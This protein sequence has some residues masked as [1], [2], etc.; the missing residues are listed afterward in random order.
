MVN[1][2]LIEK[3][4]D[5]NAY[6]VESGTTTISGQHY[7]VEAGNILV[8]KVQ[9]TQEDY[10]SSFGIEWREFKWIQ[11]DSSLGV[12]KS[13]RRLENLIDMPLECLEGK[14]V[15]EIGAGGG[16]IY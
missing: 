12:P 15:L 1:S 5:K 2:E 16:K 4:S 3:F 14:T 13:R 10:A 7:I 8:P 9:T 6:N 11:A